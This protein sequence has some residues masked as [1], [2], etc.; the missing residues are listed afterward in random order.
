MKR[1]HHVG[2]LR[3]FFTPDHQK[4]ATLKL[5]MYISCL[6][7]KIPSCGFSLIFH[8]RTKGIERVTPHGELK[9]MIFCPCVKMPPRRLIQLNTVDICGR[10]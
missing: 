5:Q 3:L 2:R 6:Y 9:M 7:E 10:S 4:T 8:S 1:G